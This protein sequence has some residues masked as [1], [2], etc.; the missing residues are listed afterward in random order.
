M[1]YINMVDIS[2]RT[3][4]KNVVE[5]IVDSHGIWNSH[6]NEKSVEERLDHKNLRVT[7]ENIF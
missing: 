7:T 1:Y 2:R 3:F 4:E 6:L 5:T